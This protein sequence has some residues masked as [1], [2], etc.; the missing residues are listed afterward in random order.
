MN[1]GH[2]QNLEKHK[3]ET[4]KLLSLLSIILASRC[5]MFIIDHGNTRIRIQFHQAMH[6]SKT[7]VSSSRCHVDTPNGTDP[8]TQESEHLVENLVEHLVE[9]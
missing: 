5:V 1:G 6:C 4:Q 2:V 9:Q 8:T 7:N 3:L